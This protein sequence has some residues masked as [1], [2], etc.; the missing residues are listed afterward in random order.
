MR[1]HVLGRVAV[2][3][4]GGEVALPK[5]RK[6]RLLLA[7]LLLHAP[8]IASVDRLCEILWGDSQP[9]DPAAA[10]RTQIS[11]CRAFL[12]EA[13]A[14]PEALHSEPYGYRMAVEPTDV[15]AGQLELLLR[16]AADLAPGREK[17]TLLEEALALWRGDPFEEFVDL[18]AFLGEVTRLRELR[19]G[20]RESRVECLLAEA[21]VSEALA[22]A[23]ELVG[24]D[25]LRERPRALLMQALYQ[26][27]RQHEALACFQEYRRQLADEL[28]LDPSPALRQLEGEILKHD[29]PA[30]PVVP[31]AY[32]TVYAP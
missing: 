18:T 10:L 2:G 12:R 23:E 6:Q 25:P 14:D 30:T 21:R 24:E 27:G 15:D 9:E 22:A 7:A 31:V 13:G 5:G 26:A 28:G 20:A 11:R 3:T 4:G 32:L 16:R 19:S 8:R 1:Y 17:A 29:R